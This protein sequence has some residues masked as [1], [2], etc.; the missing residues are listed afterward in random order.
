MTDKA[1]S[2]TVKTIMDE[3]L[4]D[5]GV[6]ARLRMILTRKRNDWEKWLQVELE[7]F[8]T[9]LPNIFVEREIPAFPD[10]RVLRDKYKMFIDLAF[11]KKRTRVNSYI[12]LE[13]KCSRSPQTLINGFNKDVKKINALRKCLLEQRSFWCV[14]FHLNCEPH[15]MKKMN[16]FVN[17]W[18]YGY[19]K[20]VKLCNC[21]DEIECPCTDNKIGFAVI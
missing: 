4:K 13:L 6:R 16:K 20:V 5:E 18:Y 14:G 7:Y 17:D 1:D 10:R 8:I 21:G 11:R 19:S 12:F 2:N 9:Q 3:F 15:N